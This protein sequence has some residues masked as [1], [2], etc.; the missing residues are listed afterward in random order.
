MQGGGR[1]GKTLSKEIKIKGGPSQKKLKTAAVHTDV[2]GV[3]DMHG[4]THVDVPTYGRGLIAPDA[5]V[6]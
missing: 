1:K 3:T 4:L 2:R 5:D 6:P